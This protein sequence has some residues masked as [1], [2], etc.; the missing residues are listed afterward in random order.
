MGCLSSFLLVF[1]TPR[2][3]RCIQIFH[4]LTYATRVRRN[5]PFLSLE[6]NCSSH[7]LSV[8]LSL[9]TSRVPATTSRPPFFTHSLLLSQQ[10]DSGTWPLVCLLR[11][12]TC[13]QT[14][15]HLTRSWRIIG[16]YQWQVPP[17]QVQSSRDRPVERNS[18]GGC[19]RKWSRALLRWIRLVLC[20]GF[21]CLCYRESTCRRNQSQFAWW[22]S[23]SKPE[24]RGVCLF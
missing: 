3:L 13:A 10:T 5:C 8:Q 15:R 6:R 1:S 24:V 12:G 23:A 16:Y 9:L 18:L 4:S 22:E 20:G 17:P 21:V 7:F 11:S 14:R 19:F 2:E